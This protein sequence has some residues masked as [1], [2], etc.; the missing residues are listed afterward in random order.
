MSIYQDLE[1]QVT[2]AI[3]AAQEAGALPPFDIP[4]VVIEKPRDPSFGDFASPVAM[5]LAKL[6][7][8][9]PIKI[10]GAIA[11]NMPPTEYLAEVSVAPPGFLNMR[12]AAGYLQGQTAAILREGGEYGRL[13]F[14][15]GKKAQ[16][17]CVSANPTGPIHFGRTRGGVMGD[18]LAR[19]MR[20][21][22]YD[23][24]LEYYYNDAGRQITMLGESTQIRYLQLLGQDVELA[25]DHYQG[26]YIIDI[27]RELHAEHGES[28]AAQEST[29]FGDYA[30]ERIAAAQKESLAQIGIIF[31]NYFREQSLYESGQVWEAIELLQKRG[32]VYE[33]EG[34]KWFRTTE[35]GD[36]KDRVLVKSSGEPTYRTPDI[37]YHWTKNS[38]VSIW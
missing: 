38:A 17:E 32:F 26:A 23:V 13:S 12:L 30:K 35:F 27:A 11:D 7:R 16:I 10:A 31:D 36:D 18:T 25:A 28:L 15:A 14:G 29:F 9:A 24:T 22:G 3:A 37:A 20:M 6:A 33:K 8:M 19:A 1:K 5:R 34:A 4:A 21:A 2:A